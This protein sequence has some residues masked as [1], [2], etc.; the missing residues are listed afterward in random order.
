MFEPLTFEHISILR[1]YFSRSRT[2]LC[3]Q[4]LGGA[5]M[6]RKSFET[7][8]ALEDNILYFSSR[9]SDNL[10]AFTM[11]LGDEQKGLDRLAEH[12]SATGERFLLTSVSEEEKE[13]I[14]ARFLN[15]SAQAKRDWFDYLYD[16]ESL[17]TFRGRKLAGQR[18]HRNFFIRQN[19]EWRFEKIGASN[20]GMARDFFDLYNRDVQ[21]DSRFFEDEKAAV[22]EF[23][24]HFDDYGFFGGMILVQDGPV[25][26]SFGERIGDTLF[27]HIEKALRQVRGSYQ[28]MVSEFVS[29]FADESTRFVNREEDLGD[30]GIRYSKESYQ[31]IRLLEKYQIEIPT[32]G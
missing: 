8:I 19:P 9:L 32:E 7:K 28:M 23:F 16:A 5:M 29:H 26:I 17:S 25:A 11:P 24:D 1:D 31:P 13:R 12:C 30:P 2:R 27:V 20:L 15:A 22:T 6:W 10:W 4:S 14:C 3:D 18:N 21:K